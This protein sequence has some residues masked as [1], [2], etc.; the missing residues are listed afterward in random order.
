MKSDLSIVSITSC[1]QDLEFVTYLY[2]G[3][4][5]LH[6][7]QTFGKYRTL[8]NLPR[9]ND[10]RS[11]Y[12]ERGFRIICDRSDNVNNQNQLGSP[13][14]MQEDVNNQT[15]VDESNSTLDDLLNN[16]DGYFNIFKVLYKNIKI[17]FILVPLLTN[18]FSTLFKRT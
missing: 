17:Y 10:N 8:S 2:D 3:Y 5:G 11:N 7:N 4:Q 13:L 14:T 16:Y 15:S 1:I 18:F 12:V 6:K 9:G